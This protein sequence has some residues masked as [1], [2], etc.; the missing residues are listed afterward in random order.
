MLLLD[1]SVLIAF[2]ASD[3]AAALIGELL[4][5]RK[6]A[7]ATLNLAEVV[8]VFGRR[9][10]SGYAEAQRAIEPLV[11]EVI[12]LRPLTPAVAWRA[13][14]VRIAHYNRRDR[15]LSMADCVLVASAEQGDT[16]ATTDS[17]LL[18]VI[19][20]EGWPSIDPRDPASIERAAEF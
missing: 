14:Q 10:P 1:A 6:S 11:A 8:D 2:L 20:A 18:E 4:R 13:A 17:D 7:I 12:A 16:L 19:A 9:S 3:P 5:E 15:P